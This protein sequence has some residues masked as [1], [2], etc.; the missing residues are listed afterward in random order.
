MQISHIEFSKYEIA[1]Q[2]ESLN[3]QMSIRYKKKIMQYC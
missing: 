3:T 2:M 1:T